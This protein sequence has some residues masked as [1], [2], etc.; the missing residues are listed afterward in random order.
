MEGVIEPT[1]SATPLSPPA[2]EK[3][4]KPRKP[5]AK[6]SAP[7]PLPAGAIFQGSNVHY[8]FSGRALCSCSSKLCNSRPI[9][10]Y[11]FCKLH[12]LEDKSAPF[13]QCEAI[14]KGRGC[15]FAIAISENSKFCGIH[16][17][18]EKRQA[19]ALQNTAPDADAPVPASSTPAP[20]TTKETA[21]CSAAP[22]SMIEQEEASN[23]ENDDYLTPTYLSDLED[24]TID[25]HTS[26]LFPQFIYSRYSTDL[27]L[28]GE[29][30]EGNNHANILGHPAFRLQHFLDSRSDKLLNLVK[31]YRMKIGALQMAHNEYEYDLGM[32]R[33][34]QIARLSNEALHLKHDAER[35]RLLL[36]KLYRRKHEELAQQKKSSDA[37]VASIPSGMNAHD[38]MNNDGEGGADWKQDVA[39]GKQNKFS[40]GSGGLGSPSSGA[41]RGSTSTKSSAQS[42]SEGGVKHSTRLVPTIPCTLTG[43]GETSLPLTKFCWCHILN[44]PLQKL[45]IACTHVAQDGKQC[46]YPIIKHSEPPFCAY[47]AEL[48]S[49]SSHI[50]EIED[51]AESVLDVED[52]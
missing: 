30:E 35:R 16:Q 52:E 25:T 44:D 10:G 4:K 7:E 48:V 27:A 40:S 18:V 26:Q 6:A 14:I 43:C 38:N 51:E 1:A 49:K 46:D 11:G 42:N 22:E 12:I 20:I 21:P 37:P 31:K 33:A 41:S 32:L 15:N 29:E 24:D 13:K 47:H 39:S 23:D 2:G 17:S 36:E 50:E 9:A 45:F 34:R 3:P 8:D 5:R 19:L 28:E